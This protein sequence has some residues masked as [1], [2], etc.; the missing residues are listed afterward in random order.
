M[1]KL[2]DRP[3]PECG[4]GQIP[5]LTVRRLPHSV[6]FYPGATGRVTALV[7]D[8]IELDHIG[9]YDAALQKYGQLVR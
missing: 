5:R 7:Y 1:W 8:V 6:V 9:K 4:P 3:V 2:C